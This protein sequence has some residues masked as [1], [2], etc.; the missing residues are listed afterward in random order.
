MVFE[1][2]LSLEGVMTHS[3]E[4]RRLIPSFLLP[5]IEEQVVMG[6]RRKEKVTPKARD[7]IG[8]A[9]AFTF[10]FRPTRKRN[11]RGD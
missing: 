10:Q 2:C 8:I 7:Q 4:D 6:L 3:N 1:R 5:T 9:A 11:S